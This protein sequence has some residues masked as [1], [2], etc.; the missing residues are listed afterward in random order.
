MITPEI[1]GVAHLVLNVKDPET[2]ARFYCDTFGFRITTRL[3]AKGLIGLTHPAGGLGLGLRT[4]G[5][6]GAVAA[7]LDHVAFLVDDR[8]V[9]EQ[10]V[11][12]FAARG[13]DAVIEDM[14][15]GSALSLRD[16]DDNE[17]E[18]FAPSRT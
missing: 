16:P 7:N 17:V 14:A 12:Q 15:D 6:P 13:V 11:R 8:T 5:M 1:R 18:L 9:L 3:E 4:S 2:T 10:C